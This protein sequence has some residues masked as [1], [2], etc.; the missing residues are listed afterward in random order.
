MADLPRPNFIDRSPASIEAELIAQWE[1]IT[2]KPLFPAQAE[3]LLINLLNYRETLVRVGIQ[4]AAEQNLVNYATDGY[5][6]QLGELLDVPRLAAAPAKTTIEFTKTGG[7]LNTSVVLP[8]GT[9]VSTANGVR[10][11]TDAD[12]IVGVGTASATVSASCVEVGLIGNGFTAGQVSTLLAPITDIASA[13]NTTISTDGAETET[14]EPYRARIKLAPEKFSVAGS[15]G[16]YRYHTLTVSQT[17]IDASVLSPTRGQV[18]VYP[19][20]TTGNPS[21]ELITAVTTAL[22]PDTIR[23]LTDMVEVLAPTAIGFTINASITLFNTADADMLLAQLNAAASSYAANQKSKLGKDIIRSQI[24]AALS[25]AGVYNI[26][27]TQP[28]ADVVVGKAEWAN[29]TGITITIAGVN[30]G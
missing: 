25:L 29:C 11:A 6:D 4:Y 30:E 1:T 24:I 10:F 18:K 7:A 16:A 26:T 3:R 8:S 21:A 23:P 13:A 27:L 20:T 22:T 14:D 17:I 19:L 5:L 9:I 12:L 15:S 2:G 28:A